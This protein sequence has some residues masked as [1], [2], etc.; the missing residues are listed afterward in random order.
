MG[1]GDLAHLALHPGR[2]RSTLDDATTGNEHAPGPGLGRFGGHPGGSQRVDGDQ[3][4]VG[5]LGQ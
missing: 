4:A 2:R 1:Q 5:R 3:D